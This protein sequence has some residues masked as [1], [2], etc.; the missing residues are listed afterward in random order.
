MTMTTLRGE[1]RKIPAYG[2]D[3]HT[4]AYVALSQGERPDL[5]KL[6]QK[7]GLDK[8]KDQP[9]PENNIQPEIDAV[10]HERIARGHPIDRYSDKSGS[11][12]VVLLPAC[13]F[14]ESLGFRTRI[15]FFD[16]TPNSEI[17]VNL[18]TYLLENG[19]RCRH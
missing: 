19:Y 10:V 9:M 3:V 16:Q 11:K 17:A 5:Y 7:Q 6:L 1:L 2:G 13:P 18:V 4:D 15:A 12:Q 8:A 14:A